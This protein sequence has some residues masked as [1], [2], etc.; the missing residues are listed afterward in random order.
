[1]ARSCP[2]RNPKLFSAKAFDNRVG[3]GLVIETLQ[4]LGDHPNTVIG[5]GSVQEEVT[6]A[7]E[8]YDLG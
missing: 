8:E 7:M 4:E 2:M 3:V 6:G 5:T 1:M